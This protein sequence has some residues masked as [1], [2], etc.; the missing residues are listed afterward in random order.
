M[1]PYPL[2]LFPKLPLTTSIPESTVSFFYFVVSVFILERLHVSGR[3]LHRTCFKCARCNH[4]LSIANYY[5]TESGSYC[6]DMCP[7]EEIEQTE[8]AEANKKIVESEQAVVI[9]FFR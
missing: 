8:V 9:F 7:D 2:R 3:L 1:L 4:Q 5:E 6:C